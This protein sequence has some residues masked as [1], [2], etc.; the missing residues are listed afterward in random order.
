MS[1][2]RRDGANAANDE[3]PIACTYARVSNPNDKKEASIESQERASVELLEAQGYRV[4]PE[5]R[6]RE[7]FTGMESIYDRPLLARIRDMAS[8]GQIQAIGCYNTDRLSRDPNE[9]TIVVRG[10]H[11]DKVKPLFVRMSQE[12]KGRMGELVLYMAGFASAVEWDEIRDRSI[13]GKQKIYD[14]GCWVGGGRVRYGYTWDKA[15]RTRSAHPEHAGIVRLVFAEIAAGVTPQQMADRLNRDGVRSP[16][17]GRW[18]GAVI[19]EMIREETYKGVVVA[20][21]TR[22]SDQKRANGTRRRERR[23]VEEHITCT[24]H[25]T[26]ALITPELWA[27]AN[28]MINERVGERRGPGG[29]KHQ[30]LFA[31]HLRCDKE[32]CGCR[33]TPEL[34]RSKKRSCVLRSY[35]CSGNQPNRANP[36]GC[37]RQL[38]AK[39]L[40]EELWA[41]VE[42]LVMESDYLEKQYSDLMSDRTKQTVGADLKA[43]LNR[44]KSIRRE[45]G[46]LVEVQAGAENR[47]LQGA[48]AD[49][50]AALEREDE[51]L[52][53]QEKL[54]RSRLEAIEHAEHTVHAFKRRLADFRTL[55]RKGDL[56]FEQKRAVLKGLQIMG[57]AAPGHCRIT[58]PIVS[59]N[60]DDNHC[61]TSSRSPG[62]TPR[63]RRHSAP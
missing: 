34:V 24:D 12:T 51:V 53:S 59:G 58:A 43:T 56:T 21:K 47:L 63:R 23:P 62:A 25:R 20:R 15:T 40:E 4:P 44:R 27:R 38:G 28:A 1:D 50:L 6:F 30:F 7:R 29:N 5:L 48:L 37:T 11:K 45:V 8:A 16:L 19:R 22:P 52:G 54:L 9:L 60:N 33:M 3:R 49:K 10:F 35:R 41:K 2:R 39:W 55:M 57:F 17:G 61:R 18:R 42:A 14:S 26:E 31:G 32:G 46:R 13:R 36:T